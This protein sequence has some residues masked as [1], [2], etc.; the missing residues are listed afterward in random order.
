MSKRNVI[1]IEPSRFRAHLRQQS[2]QRSTRLVKNR[3]FIYQN[4][5]NHWNQEMKIDC[6]RFRIAQRISREVQCCHCRNRIKVDDSLEVRPTM[7]AYLSYYPPGRR[8]H[9]QSIYRSIDWTTI[10]NTIWERTLYLCAAF[11]IRIDTQFVGLSG[12]YEFTAACCQD[13]WCRVEMR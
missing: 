12:N 1:C 3:I 4:I 9:W 5:S 7:K 6:S 13:E 11:H 10:V 2:W 8:V